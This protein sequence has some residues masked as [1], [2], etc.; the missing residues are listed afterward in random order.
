MPEHPTPHQ[1]KKDE[2]QEFKPITPDSPILEQRPTDQ[3]DEVHAVG[4]E[5]EPPTKDETA[6]ILP[7]VPEIYEEDKP[8]KEVYQ[9][10]A[11]QVMSHNGHGFNAPS[12]ERILIDVDK[13]ADPTIF[14][15]EMTIFVGK[16]EITKVIN[17]SWLEEPPLCMVMDLGNDYKEKAAVDAPKVDEFGPILDMAPDSY[18]VRPQTDNFEDF[19]TLL[20]QN[21]S[22]G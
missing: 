9:S 15:F 20:V 21:F 14:S 4:F 2:T 10:L 17:I 1:P 8:S 11:E 6:E 13:A 22:Q 7:A 16:K 3:T 5:E 12:G 19:I 18:E